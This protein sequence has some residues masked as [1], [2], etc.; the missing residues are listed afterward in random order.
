MRT[1]QSSHGHPRL[2]LSLEFDPGRPEPPRH[3][4]GVIPSRL[5]GDVPVLL[6]QQ[7]H[8]LPG[9]AAE[10]TDHD[11]D[12]PGRCSPFSLISRAGTRVDAPDRTREPRRAGP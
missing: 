1:D 2:Y 6:D 12:G 5:D 10:A 11:E 3:L 7:P 4:D 9:D 8:L